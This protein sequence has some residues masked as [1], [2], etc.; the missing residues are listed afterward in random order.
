ML[1]DYI[2]QKSPPLSARCFINLSR[3]LVENSCEIALRSRPLVYSAL[4]PTP[5]P[6]QQG[7][8]T[9]RPVP[10]TPSPGRGRVEGLCTASMAGVADGDIEVSPS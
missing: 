2:V 3:V 5:K 9:N 8:T 7:K 1:E 4:P 10:N 6:G